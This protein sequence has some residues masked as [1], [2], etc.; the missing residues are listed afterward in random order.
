MLGT[1]L[2]L[3]SFQ[4]A[5]TA[6][7]QIVASQNSMWRVFGMIDPSVRLIWFTYVIQS[8]PTIKLYEN[9][10]VANSQALHGKR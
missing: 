7:P 2:T 6:S 10:T 5:V 8:W 9:D 1:I 4:E 3:L